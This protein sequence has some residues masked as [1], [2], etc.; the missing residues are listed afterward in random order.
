MEADKAKLLM[1]GLVEKVCQKAILRAVPG[2]T[3]CLEP[4]SDKGADDVQ[5]SFILFTCCLLD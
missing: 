3:R 2:I 5:A 4:T 1:V